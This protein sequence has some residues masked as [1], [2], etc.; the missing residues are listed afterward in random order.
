MADDALTAAGTAVVRAFWAYYAIVLASS[1]LALTPNLTG[2]YEVAMRELEQV[3][4]FRATANEV[5]DHVAFRVALEAKDDLLGELQAG[6]TGS[7]DLFHVSAGDLGW[8]L[9]SPRR[10]AD[11][12]FEEMPV[13]RIAGLMT[14]ESV[15]EVCYLGKLDEVG[16]RRAVAAAREIAAG[17]TYDALP[18][19]AAI[20]VQLVDP[21]CGLWD[22]SGARD[23]QCPVVVTIRGSD[24][25]TSQEKR[26][27]AASAEVNCM[28]SNLARPAIAWNAIAKDRLVERRAFNPPE[29]PL[30]VAELSRVKLAVYG[31]KPSEAISTLGDQLREQGLGLS[32]FGAELSGR[33]VYILAPLLLFGSSIY[34]FAHVAVFRERG[35]PRS[36]F[37]VALPFISNRAASFIRGTLLLASVGVPVLI[38]DRT[39]AALASDPVTGAIKGFFLILFAGSLIAI[40]TLFI[41]LVHLRFRQM[42][43]DRGLDLW[44][45]KPKRAGP[46][47]DC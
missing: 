4:A 20:T 42:R 32:V 22:A 43:G 2:S 41:F 13:Y 24:N 9:L 11:A 8:L 28:Q 5:N 18:P 31:Q 19:D 3:I 17:R 47:I 34:L 23:V 37:P 44:P 10:S 21:R 33:A 26:V 38:V 29:K 25:T 15:E 1:L 6:M 30:D 12:T 35:V 39:L 40:Q 14:D 27:F 36:E 16:A 46:K 7:G 45:A